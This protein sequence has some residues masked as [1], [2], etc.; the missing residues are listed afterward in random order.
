VVLLAFTGLKIASTTTLSLVFPTVWDQTSH[1]F[2]FY[3]YFFRRMLSE[4]QLSQ[5]WNM[6]GLSVILCLYCHL[7]S[8]VVFETIDYLSWVSVYHVGYLK[9]YV[10][11]VAAALVF[12]LRHFVSLF[13]YLFCTVVSC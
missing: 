10:S 12:V 11:L 13:K 3:I 5:Q 6:I 8:F 4:A 1:R 9:S 2:G 7:F